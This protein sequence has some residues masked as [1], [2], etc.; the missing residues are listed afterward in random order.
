ME[1]PITGGRR[2]TI[3]LR[4][5]RSG[6]DTRRLWAYLDE[7]GALHIDGQDLGPAT[8]PVSH[9]GEYEW[10]STIRAPDV[11]RLVELLGGQTG[12]DVLTLLSVQCTGDGSYQLERILRESGIPVER[13]VY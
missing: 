9:D 5:E 2:R 13:F 1:R 12:T 4:D 6:R 10:F 3:T 7:A 11:P 8:A